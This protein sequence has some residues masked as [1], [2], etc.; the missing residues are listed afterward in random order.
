MKNETYSTSNEVDTI[1][2]WNK[3]CDVMGRYKNGSV[4]DI[5]I[6]NDAFPYWSRS[7]EQNKM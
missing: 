1:N 2:L 4:Y 7:T 5:H 6:C 3:F